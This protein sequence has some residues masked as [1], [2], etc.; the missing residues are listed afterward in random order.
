LTE[1]EPIRA[2]GGPPLVVT[3]VSRRFGG[4]LALDNVD[5][6]IEPGRV[7]A[8]VGPNGSGKTTLI[9]LV[10]GF[11]RVDKGTISLGDHQLH[12]LRAAQIA[13]LGVA[14][15]FQTPKMLIGNRVIDNV[16]VAADR[17]ARGSLAGT[18]L[19][20]RRARSESAGCRQKAATAL[21]QSGLSPASETLAELIPHGMQRLLEIARAMALE[22]TFVL[23]DEPAA[24]LSAAEVA[25]L[26]R[27][28]RDMAA[29]GLGVLIVEHNLPVVF[30]LADEV[31]VLHQ[32]RVIARGTPSHVASDPEVVR[33]YLGRQ[34]EPG[35]D[36][37]TPSGGSR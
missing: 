6:A 7:H 2:P 16:V 34:R 11:Y 30:G 33:V 24:G 36:A 22:P 25:L 5:L 23:L 4:V 10:S 26:N 32:G 18:V 35:R 3:G 27:A 13:A 20:T 37:A 1:P 12:E 15:T 31:T 28:V 29:A 21:D 19:R 14:R 17:S 9:N 8:L